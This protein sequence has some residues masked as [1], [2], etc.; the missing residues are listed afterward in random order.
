MQDIHITLQTAT[1]PIPALRGDG[2]IV[3][4]GEGRNEE[5]EAEAEAGALEDELNGDDPPEFAELKHEEEELETEAAMLS[6]AVQE[7]G[8]ALPDLQ[9]RVETAFDILQELES[10]AL[11]LESGAEE[12][13]G[14]LLDAA[15]DKSCQRNAPKPTTRVESI[16]IRQGVAKM[17]VSN[18]KNGA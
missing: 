10:S 5:A 18:M 13:R 6:D 3:I 2:E 9:G 11:A 16:R 12:T 7:L 14:A 15:L 8:A 17:T 1:A 4:A